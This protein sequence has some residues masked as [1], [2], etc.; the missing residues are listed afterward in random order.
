MQ[1]WI[2]NE[3]QENSTILGYDE[4]SKKV[5]IMTSNLSTHDSGGYIY[6]LTT[7]SITEHKNLYNWYSTVDEL[8]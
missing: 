2:I 1:S 6:D 4:Y 8:Q 5:I 3:N 7:N